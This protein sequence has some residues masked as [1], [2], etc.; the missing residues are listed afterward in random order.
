VPHR[1]SDTRVAVARGANFPAYL[2]LPRCR[3]HP[4]APARFGTL[5]CPVSTQAQCAGAGADRY[6]TLARRARARRASTAGARR[7]VHI[8]SDRPLVDSA[9]AT[10]N[11]PC[12]RADESLTR[13]IERVYVSMTDVDSEGGR[14]ALVE[15]VQTLESMRESALRLPTAA[16]SKPRR[17]RALSRR[18]RRLDP[19]GKGAEIELAPAP[20]AGW[21][22]VEV[23]VILC[24]RM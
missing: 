16:E 22:A 15:S 23:T 12:L 24:G 10:W 13:A 5:R 18:L 11:A 1:Q 9:V 20:A 14:L 7:P 8:E 6:R 19:Q 2:A 4:H 21:R 3:R 17:C